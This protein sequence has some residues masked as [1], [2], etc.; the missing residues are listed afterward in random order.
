MLR[1]WPTKMIGSIVSMSAFFVVYF[2]ILN[3]PLFPLTTIPRT[4][5]DTLVPFFP[6]ALFL[7]VSLWVY[8]PLAPSLLG[9]RR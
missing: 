4:F 3:H 6:P 9:T 1:F 5:L 7:Y 2:W 8:V